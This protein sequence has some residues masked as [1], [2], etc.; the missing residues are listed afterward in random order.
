MPKSSLNGSGGVVIC[1]RALF[2]ICLLAGGQICDS[3]GDGAKQQPYLA[4]HLSGLSYRP[5]P[6]YDFDITPVS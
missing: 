2:H 6:A 4:R 3:I 1:K 5:I